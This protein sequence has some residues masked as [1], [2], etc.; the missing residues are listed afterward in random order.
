MTLLL[1]F[2]LVKILDVLQP[3]TINWPIAVAIGLI[4]WIVHLIYN[5]T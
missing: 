2:E 3:G 1:Y 4:V 5:A